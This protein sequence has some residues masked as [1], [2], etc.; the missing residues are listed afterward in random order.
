MPSLYEPITVLRILYILAG[1]LLGPLGIVTLL[2]CMLLGMCGMNSFGIPYTAPIAPGSSAFW[3]WSA[4][5]GATGIRWRG[6]IFPLT[7]CP[8]EWKRGR[9][10]ERAYNSER[11]TALYTGVPLIGGGYGCAPI[12]PP[13]ARRARRLRFRPLSSTRLW[14][15]Y[16]FCPCWGCCG[17]KPSPR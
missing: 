11:K 14:S 10:N 2:F 9:R 13:E 7:S 3:S 16:C 6:Q 1:G 12:L 5:C 15:A 17:A 8:E 4:C